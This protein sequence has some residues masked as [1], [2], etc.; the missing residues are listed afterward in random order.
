MFVR[1][2]N[3]LFNPSSLS[4]TMPAIMITNLV[5]YFDL[6]FRPKITGTSRKTLPIS[7]NGDNDFLV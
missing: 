5:F 2:D 1:R 7:E 3:E 4:S 6:Q